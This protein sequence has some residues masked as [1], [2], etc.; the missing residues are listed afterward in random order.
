MGKVFNYL[1]EW[2]RDT[3]GIF[4]SELKT[5]VTDVGVMVILVVAGFLY[6]LLYNK[7]Y[8]NGILEDTP[9][10]VVDDADCSESRE[11]IR[12][13]DATREIHIAYRCADMPEA[14]K[15]FQEREVN[16]IIYFPEDF[17]TKL[18]N[19]ETTVL[20]VYTDMSSFMYYKNLLMASQFVMLHNIG[21]IQIDRYSA[22]GMTEQEAE[23]LVRPVIYEEN[24]PYNVTFSYSIFLI[25]AILLL[26]VQQ[27]MLYG[28][29]LCVGTMREEKNSFCSLVDKFA[30]K[31]VGRVIL[32]RGLAYWLIFMVIGLY[33]AFIVPAIFDFPQRGQFFDILLLLVS[34]VTDCVFFSMVWSSLVTKRESV[35]LLMLFMSPICLFLTGFSWPTSAFPPFWKYFSYLFPSTFACR[36][37]INLNTAGGDLG[38]IHFQLRG[39]SFQTIGYFILSIILI[40]YENFRLTHKSKL[41]AAREKFTE[42]VVAGQM[43]FDRRIDEE[44]EQ[45][46]EKIGR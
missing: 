30:G 41:A 6:P 43:K 25:S 24:N 5:L 36:G 20:S 17:G 11:Y 29:S 39:I 19:L 9:I 16:G 13:L 33:I 42:T 21:Q 38:S 2:F 7:I 22:M 18:A 31:G 37:F 32:G 34:F 8:E 10:A 23:Q 46:K 40:Y 14:E 26:I 45:I 1:K 3:V 44:L 12:E 27:V 15:L 4:Y 35:F 28:M